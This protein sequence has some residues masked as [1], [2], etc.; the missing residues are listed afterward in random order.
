MVYTPW[1]VAA[2]IEDS[3]KGIDY[4]MGLGVV[5]KKIKDRKRSPKRSVSVF[6]DEQ[7]I[8]LYHNYNGYRLYIINATDKDERFDTDCGVLFAGTKAYIDDKWQSIEEKP[9]IISCSFTYEILKTGY[10]WEFHVPKFTGEI[11]VKI[12]YKVYAGG[13]YIYSNEI[14]AKINRGQ[15]TNKT[16][17]YPEWEKPLEEH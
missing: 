5:A 1:C 11:P 8:S 14:D 2:S 9:L 17:D 16:S 4:S 15:L 13:T 3:I 10:Y 6:L 7:V 12:R